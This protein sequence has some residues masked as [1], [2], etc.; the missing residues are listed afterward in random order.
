MALSRDDKVSLRQW[1]RAKE[2]FDIAVDLEPGARSSY[3]A[4][5][6]ADDSSLLDEVKELL[7]YYDQAGSFLRDPIRTQT[8]E[9]PA[10]PVFSTGQFVANRFRIMKLVGSGGMGEVYV[11]Y[12]FELGELV[13]LKTLRS[14]MSAD[15][16]MITSFKQEV[17]LAR[18]VTHPNV[19]RIFDMFWHHGMDG[20][21]IAV[22]T[23]EYL[24]GQTL[25]DRI[26]SSGPLFPSEALPMIRQIAKGLDAAHKFGIIHRDFK[27]SNV[28]LVPQPDGT[29]RAVI[30]DFGLASEQYAS[31][32]QPKEAEDIA[33][34]PAYIAPE[35]LQ[36]VTLTPSVDIYAF[37]VV[38]FEMLTGR[39]PFRGGPGTLIAIKRQQLEPPSP[40]QY[41]DSLE[42]HWESTIL[43]C[44]ASEPRNRPS[45]A[46]EVLQSLSSKPPWSWRR[47]L[48]IAIT[49]LILLAATFFS[50]RPHVIN[51]EAQAAL[52]SARV[53][54][55][56]DSKDGFTKAIEDYKLAVHLDPNWAQPWAELAYAYATASN[57]R[58]D[59]PAALQQA[60]NAALKAISLD[61]NLGKAYGA[62]GWTQS[63]D[64]DE[65]PRAEQSFRRALQL[66]PDDGQIHYW[67]GVHLRKKGR[68]REAEEQDKSALSL[69]H[70]RDPN[71]WSELAFLYWTANQIQKF[72]QHMAEQLKAYPNFA[73]TRYLHARLLKLEQGFDQAEE[74][75]SFAE[76]LGMN[77][78]TVM[79]ER[80]SL[81]EHQENMSRARDYVSTLETAA[82]FQEVD[83]LLLAGVYAGLRDYDAAFATLERAYE[84]KD[85]TLLSLATS[86]VVASL[87]P[88][89]RFQVLLK[90]LHFN[91]QIMQQMEFSS[92]SSNGLSSQPRRTG[93]S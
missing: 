5:T 70:Q 91:D 7:E 55:E 19:C 18:R 16:R 22:L 72:H 6:C 10:T 56:N 27:S 64:F 21:P 82:R 67:F 50:F 15:A 59:G 4:A 81:A 79:V 69:T 47:K 93:T 77:P 90:K 68:F 13:A 12:D 60:R 51:P 28:M 3:L 62:L 74:E 85:N 29:M 26:H 36:N 89:L 83:G 87:R 8:S 40:G 42:P 39:L 65:W 54:L 92:F 52:D 17:H 11:A 34:T 35:Q 57:F 86:P 30:T 84:R 14:I 41:T 2:I 23:M 73:L 38:L 48:T 58:Y 33:G 49:T 1:E 20:S 71:V 78:V 88:D 24:A 63:L 25:S 76:K 43:K 61:S 45:S 9:E 53:A 32:D 46:A 66:S 37:G 80:A 44:L 31:A 75:L